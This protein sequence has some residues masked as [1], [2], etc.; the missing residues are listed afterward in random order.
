MRRI[1]FFILTS[2]IL[3]FSCKKEEDSAPSSPYDSNKLGYITIKFDSQ[4]GDLN[5]F[6]DSLFYTNTYNQK[7]SISK[8]SY[9][10]SNIVFVREDSTTYT[11]PQDS[12][13]F[14]IREDKY[15]SKILKLRV[16]EGDYV[17]VRFM[18]GVDSLRST[19]PVNE[20]TGIL[21]ISGDA[22]SMY[23]TWNSGYIFLKMEGNY[24]NPN[25][26]VVSEEP[27]QFHIGGFGPTI[28]NIRTTEVDFRE[29]IASV[30]QSK[31]MLWPEVHIYVDASKV[32]SGPTNLDFTKNAFVMFA[33]Y[34]LN[35]SN[36]YANMFTLAHVHDE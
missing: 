26:T 16:P 28:N 30:R 29:Y 2:G 35:I 20:R 12:S 25:D 22:A 15:D 36:N 11:I 24:S 5:L 14:L 21:D 3:L 27:Y 17:K 6:P 31:G 19:K 8:L 32:I 13:Y 1:L 34:S 7:F 4:V 33:P 10:I 23:W 9:F 18:I